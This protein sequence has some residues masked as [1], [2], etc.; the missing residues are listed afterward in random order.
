MS[1]P[2][3][4]HFHPAGTSLRPPGDS[5][6]P[7]RRRA[8]GPAGAGRVEVTAALPSPHPAGTGNGL[9]VDRSGTSAAAAA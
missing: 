4:R 2:I 8:L 9:P 1:E 3:S 7:S 5:Q 6:R